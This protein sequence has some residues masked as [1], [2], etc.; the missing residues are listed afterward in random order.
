MNFHKGAYQE[1]ARVVSSSFLYYESKK[2]HNEEYTC[3]KIYESYYN[4]CKETVW[5]SENEGKIQRFNEISEKRKN[6]L[7]EDNIFRLYKDILY[8]EIDLDK[9]DK[10]KVFECL[11]ILFDVL[12]SYGYKDKQKKKNLKKAEAEFFKELKKGKR[13]KGA[14]EE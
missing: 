1:V 14:K 4:K 10:K 2:E 5:S 7:E 8:I 11:D 6:L 3:L 12:K 13:I 9:K